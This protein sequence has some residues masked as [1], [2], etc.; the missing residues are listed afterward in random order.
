M[1]AHFYER[2]EMSTRQQLISEAATGAA[3]RVDAESVG[4]DPVT[5]ITILTQVLPL[6]ISCFKRND[7]PEPESIQKAVKRQCAT[8]AGRA[9]LRRR[10]MRRVR[11]ESDTHV[12]KEQAFALADAIIEESM[13]Q[14]PQLV[15]AVCGVV[16]DIEFGD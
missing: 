14:N 16:S 1:T 5:I 4:L 10:T 3:Q 12:S 8:P 2:T 7:E 11:S 15:S 13:N 6:V 9:A